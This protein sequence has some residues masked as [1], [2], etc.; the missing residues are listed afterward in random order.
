M[1]SDSNLDQSFDL[2][3]SNL[4]RN[5]LPYKVSEKNADYDFVNETSDV[6]DQKIEVISV[7]SGPIESLEIQSSGDNYKV[8]DKLIFDETNTS[9]SGLDVAVESIKGKKYYKYKTTST[10]YQNSIFTWN[11]SNKIK[12]SILP[13]HNLSSLDYVTISGF[14]TNLSKLNGTHRILFLLT[15]MEDVYLLTTSSGITTEIYVAPIP[16]QISVGSSIGIGT[17]TLKVLGVFRNEN[18]LRIERG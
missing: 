2:N 10:S 16:E 11:S 6:L 15:Q 13:N 9:G 4:L 7:T 17:E 8:G 14:S 1:P 18:I 3:N 12:V 5:T